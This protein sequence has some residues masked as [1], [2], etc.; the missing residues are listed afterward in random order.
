MEKV[1]VLNPKKRK[2]KNKNRQNK[3]KTNNKMIDLS[4]A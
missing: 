4:V 3:Q 2:E 1:K